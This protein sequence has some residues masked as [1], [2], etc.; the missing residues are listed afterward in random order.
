MK[1]W[2]NERKKEIA[3]KLAKFEIE[4]K[5]GKN[6][7]KISEKGKIDIH[8]PSPPPPSSSAIYP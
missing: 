3:K 8:K 7:T 2:K 6:E 1:V 5:G 4:E